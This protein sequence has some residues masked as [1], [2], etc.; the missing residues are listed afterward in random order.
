MVWWQKAWCW[1][2]ST[3]LSLVNQSYLDGLPS[4]LPHCDGTGVFLHRR[5]VLPVVS[6][7]SVFLSLGSLSR[8]DEVPPLV[9]SWEK[10]QGKPSVLRT[11]MPEN[12]FIPSSCNLIVWLVTGHR[13]EIMSLHHFE[14]ITPCVLVFSIVIKS[15]AILIFAQEQWGFSFV[16]MYVYL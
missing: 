3:C 11:F 12:G 5:P 6:C 1:Q 2:L 13:R 8:F 15:K 14:S 9:H 10:V 7:A 16:C 4:P